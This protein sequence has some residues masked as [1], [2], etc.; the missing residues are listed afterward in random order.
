MNWLGA[1][2][3][4]SPEFW[5]NLQKAYELDLA[6]HQIGNSLQGIRPYQRDAMP[7]LPAAASA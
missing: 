3:D 6:R 7:N 2:F 5:L 4:V 1:F